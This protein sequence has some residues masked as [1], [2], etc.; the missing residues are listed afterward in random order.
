MG[1]PVTLNQLLWGITTAI[2]I[3][4]LLVYIISVIY[5]QD[6]YEK[7]QKENKKREERERENNR[8]NNY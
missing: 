1:E 5:K 7:W 6:E 4:P 8:L 2:I 3:L